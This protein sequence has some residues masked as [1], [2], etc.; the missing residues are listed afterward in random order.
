MSSVIERE[1]NS[2]KQ[3]I[4]QQIT[5]LKIQAEQQNIDP[6]L[7]MNMNGDVMINPLLQTKATILAALASLEK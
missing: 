5:N 4:D 2:L 3:T 1:L 6:Y 7:M